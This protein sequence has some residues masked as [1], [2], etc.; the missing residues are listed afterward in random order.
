MSNHLPHLC[1]LPMVYGNSGYLKALAILKGVQDG[2][3]KPAI[4]WD[5]A[6]AIKCG[7]DNGEFFIAKKSM[8]K[9]FKS[10]LDFESIDDFDLR[11]KMENCYCFLKNLLN[12]NELPDVRF[13]DMLYTRNSLA[14]EDIDGKPHFTFTPN[15][16]TYAVRLYNRCD[17]IA[18]FG[19]VFHE[20]WGRQHPNVFQPLT[21]VR[22]K[23]FEDPRFNKT[24]EFIVSRGAP[25]FDIIRKDE[26]QKMRKYFNHVV[27]TKDHFQL[28]PDEYIDLYE[29]HLSRSTLAEVFSLVENLRF[30]TQVALEYLNTGKSIGTYL[31]DESGSLIPCGHEGFVAHGVKLV[32]RM[33]FSKANFKKWDNKS[34][35]KVQRLLREENA[36]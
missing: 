32:N 22:C 6:P 24:M 18:S 7:F 12:P 34:H 1:E 31:R 13:G 23:G 25:N 4:K 16:I 19:F 3:I 9:L 26:M 21:H 28:D 30:A 14:L 20:G 29:H 17:T 15:T 2:F 36:A 5:G 10:E 27:R 35:E 11:H 8:A 33:E